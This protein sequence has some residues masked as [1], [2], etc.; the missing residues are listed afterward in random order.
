MK[1]QRSD[2]EGMMRV[3]FALC[4]SSS[5]QNEEFQL[6]VVGV[7]GDGLGRLGAYERRVAAPARAS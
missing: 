5:V 4:S 7:R 6:G 3:S 1:R 2:S